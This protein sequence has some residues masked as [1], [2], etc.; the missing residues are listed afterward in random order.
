M[1]RYGL[2]GTPLTHSWSKIIH[3]TLRNYEYDIFDVPAKNFDMWI[4]ESEFAGINVTIPYK[5]RVIPHCSS[6]SAQAEKIGSVN[7]IVRDRAG[8]LRGY[9]TDYDGFLYM[10]DRA[11]IFFQDRK[12]LI[13]GSGGT[14]KTVQVAVSDR[15]AREV[16]VGSRDGGYEYY[17]AEII[18][19]TTPV[20]MYPNSGVSLIDL[21]QFPDCQGVIDVIYNPMRTSLTMDAEELGIPCTNGLSMLVAQAKYAGDLFCG[22]KIDDESID[23]VVTDITESLSN[24]VIIGM[25]G[26]GKSTLGRNLAE[27]LGSEWKDTDAEVERKAGMSI[28]DIFEKFGEREFRKI[29]HDVIDECG[30]ENGLVISTGGGSVLLQENVRALR[31]NGIIIWIQR[32]ISELPT[33]GRPLSIDLEEMY[34]NRAPLYKEACDLIVKSPELR[35][36]DA[37]KE[38]LEELKNALAYNKRT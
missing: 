31:Q 13:L 35:R 19:N 33:S 38:M 9:N 10:A 27:E 8:S 28:P 18:I 37:V 21:N 15:G 7:A 5:Q 16:F 20:G 2:L 23:R 24:I 17:D 29:E 3:E 36:E 6:L 34:K 1:S 26:S 11:G 4:R 14:S 25:P 12:V 22:D 30:K 32:D